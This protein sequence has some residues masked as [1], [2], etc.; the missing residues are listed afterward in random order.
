LVFFLTLFCLNLINK[1]NKKYILY[2][3][4]RHIILFIYYYLNCI[5]LLVL[6]SSCWIYLCYLY[7]LL[8]INLWLRS[9]S[10]LRRAATNMC[11]YL[12][13][14]YTYTYTKAT[15]I[16]IARP[17][18]LLRIIWKIIIQQNE[19]CAEGM[20][21]INLRLREGIC[22]VYQWVYLIY[23]FIQLFTMNTVMI[24]ILSVAWV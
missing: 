13:A 3:F 19:F 22:D 14:T 20:F 21:M 11:F 6:S 8:I 2:R 4:L 24:S 1:N 15:D 23:G 18:C 9:I 5:L 10:S 16:I 7:S 17:F 12:D